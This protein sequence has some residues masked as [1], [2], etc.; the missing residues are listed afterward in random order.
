M[1]EGDGVKDVRSAVTRVASNVQFGEDQSK[2]PQ[3]VLSK[4]GNKLPVSYH[5]SQ[6]HSHLLELKERKQTFYFTDVS[7]KPILSINQS[8][9][10]PIKKSTAL[11]DAVFLYQYDF[12]ALNRWDHGQYVMQDIVLNH[13]N[14]QDVSSKHTVLCDGMR[15]VLEDTALSMAQKAQLIT[16]PSLSILI[17]A[18]DHVDPLKLHQSLKSC[19][20][21]T[22]KSLES[23]L[24]NLYQNAKACTQGNDMEAI[25]ARRLANLCLYYLMHANTNHAHLAQAQYEEN[26]GQMTLLMGALQAVNPHKCLQRNTLMSQFK[27]TF[28]HDPLVMDK[29]FALSAMM[30]SDHKIDQLNAL[31]EDSCYRSDNPN[32]IRSLWLMFAGHQIPGFHAHDSSGYNAL[33]ELVAYWDIRNPQLAAQL[34]Q[35]FMSWE[36]YDRATATR[37]RRCLEKLQESAG[38][39]DLI[40]LLSKALAAPAPS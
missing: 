19:M 40:E 35:P 33:I 17:Q 28:S 8:F 39:T 14:S 20:V 26:T 38:S 13:Y 23:E 31:T 18:I 36:Q 1:L 7:E 5:Q 27:Q 15:A 6:S 3:K 22:A 25:G 32:C 24:L 11:D 9:S 37:M 34:I 16:W 21:N 29:W 4:S 12:D 10:S 2:K 30:P